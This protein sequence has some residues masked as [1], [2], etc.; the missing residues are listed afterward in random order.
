MLKYT[1]EIELL[2]K[3]IPRNNQHAHKIKLLYS[4][5]IYICGSGHISRYERVFLEQ[6]IRGSSPAS[7]CEAGLSYFVYNL[8]PYIVYP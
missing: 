2:T 4:H 3:F 7:N 6:R 5:K 1:L 8:H